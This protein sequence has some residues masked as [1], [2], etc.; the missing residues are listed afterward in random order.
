MMLYKTNCNIFPY[1]LFPDL[2]SM[3]MHSKKWTCAKQVTWQLEQKVN[4]KDLQMILIESD[5]S[6]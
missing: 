6:E 4:C 3:Y 5:I 1:L 2:L